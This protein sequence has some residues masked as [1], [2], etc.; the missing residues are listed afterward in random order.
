MLATGK[1]ILQK[2]DKGGYAVGAFNVVNMEM[3]Q[4]IIAAAEKEKAPVILQTSEGALKYMG[5]QLVSA[6]VRTMAEQASV[7][8][9]LNLDHGTTYESAMDCV[10]NGWTAVMI[11][12]SHH[13][14]EENIALTKKVVEGAHAKGVSVEAELGKLAGIEDNISVAEKDAMHTDPEEAKVFMRETG[15]DYLAVAIGTAHGKYKGKPELDFER[16]ETLKKDLNVPIVLHGASGIEADDIKRAISLGVNK[17]NIDT[18]LRIAF[19][20]ALRAELA[21]DANVFDLRKFLGPARDAVTEVVAAKM[22][23]FG[24]SGKA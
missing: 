15:V 13:A 14:L 2:A 12:G 9:A 11:D 6:M 10:N 24:A 8:V 23:L 18:D 19:T 4:A 17:I 1:E 21:K 22:R 7:P 16:L 20:D 5:T 3:V